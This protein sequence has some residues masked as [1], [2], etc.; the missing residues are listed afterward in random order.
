MR[1]LQE[2]F[3]AVL[4]FVIHPFY[5]VAQTEINIRKPVIDVEF[6]TDDEQFVI[7][8]DKK[9]ELWHISGYLVREFEETKNADKHLYLRVSPTNNYLV[10]ISLILNHY[11]VGF[12]DFN[13][14]KLINF[15]YLKDEFLPSTIEFSANDEFLYI[16]ARDG[17]IL[18]YGFKSSA[19]PVYYS[20]HKKEVS[21]IYCTSDNKY[22]FSNSKDKII[23]RDFNYGNIIRIFKCP[24]SSIANIEVSKENK[25]LVAGLTN[26]SLLIYDVAS[27][28]LIYE[29]R[30][31]DKEIVSLNINKEGSLILS[32]SSNSVKLWSIEDGNNLRTYFPHNNRITSINFSPGSKYFASSSIDGW[33]N[34]WKSDFEESTIIAGNENLNDQK[35]EIEDKEASVHEESEISRTSEDDT[36]TVPIIEILWKSPLSVYHEV[37]SSKYFI[38]ATVKSNINLSD[39]SLFHDNKLIEMTD[40]FNE[41]DDYYFCNLEELVELKPGI[42][43]IN[44]KVTDIR[45]GQHMENRILNYTR[46]MTDKRLALV[47]GNNDYVY[48]GSLSNPY[49]DAKD[50]ADTLNTIGFD[51]MSYLNAD[52]KT[53]KMAMDKFGDELEN[54]NVGLFYYAGHGVQVKGINYI[55]PVDANLKREQDVEYD[56]VDIGRVLGKMET[57]ENE[58]NIIILDACRDN[59]FERSWAG[60]SAGG[61]GLA[62]MTAPSGSLIAYS[63]SPGKTAS[64]GYQRNGLYTGTLL[65]YIKQNNLLIEELFKMVRREVESK[66]QGLQTPWESTSLKG[67]F[68]FV[69]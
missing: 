13:T 50:I 33:V 19:K 37:V 43:N 28:E 39:V 17:T 31:H 9:I 3:V 10:C 30:G 16:G 36:Y 2:Y 66:S 57:A 58:T 42:N 61:K 54:Y 65:K 35:R 26:G 6:S 69:K 27:G 48:G 46:K 18:K 68:Y 52:Q 55:I 34:I 12:W 51:V 47:I 60:R 24:K 25:Y 44:I 63:T 8:S 32:A 38:Y 40:I 21:S 5:S 14:G 67:K 15:F 41:S 4:I 7:L 22:V 45:Y 59:P 64:D 20:D 23:Q 62:F 11:K 56:C 1:Y 29:C 53:L 49:N